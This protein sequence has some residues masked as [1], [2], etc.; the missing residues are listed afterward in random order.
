MASKN[1][2]KQNPNISCLW[3]ALVC[4]ELYVCNT[5]SVGAARDDNLPLQMSKLTSREVT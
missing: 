5:G 4:L 3:M 1:K 2:I